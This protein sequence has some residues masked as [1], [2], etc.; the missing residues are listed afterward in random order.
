MGGV[1]AAICRDDFLGRGWA[2]PEV[3]SCIEEASADPTR[4]SQDVENTCLYAW[5]ES[6]AEAVD[7]ECGGPPDYAVADFRNARRLAP[8]ELVVL[9]LG[10]TDARV[11]L[12]N[13]GFTFL[14]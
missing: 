8:E 4:T 1:N 2:A 6:N 7:A 5:A 12:G 9:P 14:D 11:A 13:A 10:Q 3:I